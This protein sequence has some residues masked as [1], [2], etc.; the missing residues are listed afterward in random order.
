MSAVSWLRTK[1]KE[2]QKMARKRTDTNII[3]VDYKPQHLPRISLL[4]WWMTPDPDLEY[5]RQLRSQ[6]A[7]EIAEDLKER[8]LDQYSSLEEPAARI[9]TTFELALVEKVD[10]YLKYCSLSAARIHA[11]NETRQKRL[12]ED[13]DVLDHLHAQLTQYVNDSGKKEEE[14]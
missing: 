11:E 13:I 14:S 7:A 3:E 6:L 2:K 4:S 5:F 8:N 12:H 9:R 10:Q 1:S